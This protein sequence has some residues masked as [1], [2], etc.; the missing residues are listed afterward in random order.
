MLVV[1][2]LARV[3]CASN[4]TQKKDQALDQTARPSTPPPNS[5]HIDM[6]NKNRIYGG[7]SI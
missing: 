2:T 4:I 7:K 5:E 6:I 1:Y 3:K